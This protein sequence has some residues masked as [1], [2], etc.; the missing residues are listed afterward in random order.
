MANRELGEVDITINGATYTLVLNTNAMVLLEDRFSTKDHEVTFDQVLARVSAGSVRH[1][2]AF[3]WAALQAHHRELTIEQVG[4]LIQAAGG[5]QG[6]TN[7][8][9]TMVAGTRPEPED[10]ATV[11]VR[12]GNPRKAQARNG[13]AHGTG[14]RSSA[15]R[16]ASA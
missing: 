1:I 8:L 6:F 7:Q 13:R 5:L 3:V 11:G 14:A 4:D 10:L 16:A 9:I 12:P 2:R 15:T